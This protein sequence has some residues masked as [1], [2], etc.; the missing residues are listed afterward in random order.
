MGLFNF[1]KKDREPLNEAPVEEYWSL[2]TNAKEI[3]D[4]AWEQVE[5]A[6]KSALPEQDIFA[7]L[8]YM[9][10]GLEIEI[11]QVT[12]GEG[13]YRFEALP[14]EG[15]YDYGDI[16]INDRISYDEAIGFFKEFYEN[17]RVVGYRSWETMKI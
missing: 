1:F 14:P 3:T 2:T 6:V 11:I 4:P 8:G 12:G 5:A 7:S 9:N 15:S 17:Q 10:S 16:Y 13:I